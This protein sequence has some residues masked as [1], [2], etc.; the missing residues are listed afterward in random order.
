MDQISIGFKNAY[1]SD[2]GIFAGLGLGMALGAMAGFDMGG[3]INKIAFVT[4]SALI[5]AKIYEPMGAIAAA[6]PVAPLGMGLTT[7][8]VPKFFDKDTRSMG[9]A[10]II[11]GC[12]GISE[13]AIPF[14]IRDPKRA[15]VSNVLGSAIAGGIAGALMV[16]NAA[17][18][19]GPIVAILGAVPYGVETLYFFIAIAAGVA[20]TTS[21]YAF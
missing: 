11:M 5:T 1:S 10:A 18:H 19:G 16:T 12:I 21:V 6:I 9:I 13:G 4:G 2:L 17:A 14:A 7:I 8:I 20:V 3:P 15:V